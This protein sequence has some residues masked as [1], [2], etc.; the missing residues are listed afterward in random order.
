MINSKQKFPI[1]STFRFVINSLA[2]V[3]YAIAHEWTPLLNLFNWN[4]FEVNYNCFL[5]YDADLNQ[6][7][8]HFRGFL[9]R[10]MW[11]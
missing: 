7:D 6:F 9:I 4:D 8:L 1:H 3:C 5:G 2:G 10:E 11:G